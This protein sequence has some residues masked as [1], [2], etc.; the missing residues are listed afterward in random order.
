[1]VET[2]FSKHISDAGDLLDIDKA[3]VDRVIKPERVLESYVSVVVDGEAKNFRCIR[4]QHSS[5]LGPYKGGIRFHPEVTLEE[6]L[7]LAQTMTFK[8]AVVDVPFG[9]AKGGVVCN[10][11]EMSEKELMELSR[12]YIESLNDFIGPE[13]DIP[14]P[15]VNT[16]PK[17]MAVMMDSYSELVGK[18]V[19]AVVTGKPVEVGGTELRS[20]A[21]GRGVATVYHEYIQDHGYSINDVDVAIQGYGKVGQVAAELIDSYGSNVVGLSDSTGAIIDENGLPTTEIREWKEKTGS[22][23]GFNE[24]TEITNKELLTLDVDVLIPAALANAINKEIADQIQAEVIIEAANNP[25]TPTADKILNEK[26][27]TIIPDILANAGGVTASYLEWVQNMQHHSWSQEKLVNELDTKMKTAYQNVKKTK[28]KKP[29][30]HSYR[31]S[32]IQMA[33]QKLTKTLKLRK[34]IFK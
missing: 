17:N 13:K 23:I 25:I 32:A 14:A 5:L 21:T 30:T 31:E 22:V 18:N 11:K 12:K 10:P 4:C 7:E 34:P 29:K 16:G 33:L 9:G 2:G 1:M 15:D 3:I 20:G 27:H 28:T 19:P 6:S 24:T 8:N 26:N